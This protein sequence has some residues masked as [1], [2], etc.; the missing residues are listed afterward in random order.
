M[1][2]PLW[3]LYKKK[4][5]KDTLSEYRSLRWQHLAGSNC[6]EWYS[7][8]LAETCRLSRYLHMAERNMQGKSSEK[9][10]QESK[11]SFSQNH[12][13]MFR[14]LCHFWV[15]EHRY[16]VRLTDSNSPPQMIDL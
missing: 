6:W 16:T 12:L 8:F 2:Q 11:F 9:K 10:E 5:H 13:I 4:F 14:I 1:V 15:E 3:G 7:L